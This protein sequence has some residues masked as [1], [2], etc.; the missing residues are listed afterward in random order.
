MSLNYANYYARKSLAEMLK[1]A[2]IFDSGE[3]KRIIKDWIN[4]RLRDYKDYRYHSTYLRRDYVE[5]KRSS[6]MLGGMLGQCYR[7]KDIETALSIINDRAFRTIRRRGDFISVLEKLFPE[8]PFY[9]CDDCGEIMDS[10]GDRINWAYESNPICSDCI[11]ADYTFYDPEDTYIRNSDYNERLSEDDDDCDDSIIGEYHSS[12]PCHIPST[13]DNRKPKVLIGL[14]LEIE[15]SERHER[16]SKA[17]HMLN[18]I[19]TYR[20]EKTGSYYRYC[21]AE[22]DGSLDYGFEIVT[23]FTGLDIH[24]KQLE[25]F[26]NPLS[27]LK[28]HNTSTCGLHVHICKSTMSLY[29]GAKL[30]LFINDEKNSELI[31]T[32]ARRSESGYAKIKNKKDNIV[33]LKQ[34]RETRNPLNNLN[35]D[36]YE[37]LNFQN[38]NTIEFRLFKGTLKYETIQACLEFSFL[39]WHFTKDASIKDLTSAKFLEFINKPENRSDSIY[40]REYLQ[41]KGFMNVF[42]PNK[43]IA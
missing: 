37:A 9:S 17:E 25:Y 18:V 2:V 31:K 43:K 12:D 19:G 26:K 34:A 35:N 1:D 13:F 6:Q 27:G 28:S 10:E 29:H 36:R 5:L 8:A 3:K 41:S 14:E 30:I 33:W 11:E 4:Y 40:L 38:P 7:D 21:Q 22:R 15:V 23:G 32:I 39:S 42:V 16:E 24:R 20:N